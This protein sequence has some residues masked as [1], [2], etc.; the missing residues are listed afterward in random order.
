M[1]STSSEEQFVI[2]KTHSCGTS[3]SLAVLFYVFPLWK[4]SNSHSPGKVMSYCEW[5]LN[6]GVLNPVHNVPEG[7][8]ICHFL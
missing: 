8:F 2:Y 3:N 6:D 4:L 5:A 1:S 7:R